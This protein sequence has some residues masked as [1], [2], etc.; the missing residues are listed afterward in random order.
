MTDLTQ[1]IYQQLLELYIFDLEVELLAEKLK[2]ANTG[3]PPIP[4]RYPWEN[5]QP[6]PWTQPWRPGDAPIYYGPP[7]NVTCATS[8]ITGE[9]SEED[10]GYSEQYDAYYNNK[11]N[12]WIDPKCSD[13]TCHYC[14]TRPKRPL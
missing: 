9:L 5:P 1:E 6:N 13:R 10:I 14:T 12:E 11:T 7:Y 8:F 2:N 4:V 3:I